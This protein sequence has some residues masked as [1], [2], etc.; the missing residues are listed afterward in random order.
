[1]LQNPPLTIHKSLDTI[2]A[3]MI[4]TILFLLTLLTVTSKLYSQQSAVPTLKI[5]KPDDW[6]DNSNLDLL[7]NLE[8]YEM[9]ESQLRSLINSNRGSI[10][11][12]VYMKYNPANYPGIIPT[13]QINL[14]P[15]PNKEFRFFKMSMEQSIQQMGNMLT[16]FEVI[17]EL[18]EVE[19]DGRKGVHFLASFEMKLPDG[20]LEKIRSWTYAIPIGNYFYQIN[21]SDLYEKDNCEEIYKN[22]VGSI[23][24]E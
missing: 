3:T 20:A 24:I 14:R 23:E 8:K 7:A 10:P 16:N 4:R 19:I 17:D 6:F 15:N 13:I 5:D 18:Q 22:L 1:M 12:N 21:F 11:I 9:E 2:N